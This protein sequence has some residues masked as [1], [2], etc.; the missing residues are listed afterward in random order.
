MVGLRD[1]AK[2]RYVAEMFT[3]I[4]PRYDLMNG[5]MT[6]GMHHRW[7][8]EAAAAATRGVG[9][10][11]LDVATGTGDLALALA[12]RPEVS[13]VVGVDLLP[14]MVALARA[15]ARNGHTGSAVS[16]AVADGPS[17]PFPSGV[18]ACAATAWGLRNMP[19]PREALAEMVRVVKPGG[20]VVSLDSFA[21]EGTPWSRGFRL[22]FHHVVPLMGQV[23]AGDR[24]AYTYLPRSVDGF[25]SA[26][27]LEVLMAEAG[28]AEVGH[29]KAG[30][31]AV[32]L[33]WGKVPG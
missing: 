13:R 30:L 25:L 31:G 17:L 22:F 4:A 7:R 16:F 9:G 19:D 28:L 26:E 8:R 32:G 33:H 1:N 23:F 20:M 5:L 29:R 15:K 3:R 14:E 27:E 12:R 11:A 18:F 24:A 10:A 6:G 2:R 21:V